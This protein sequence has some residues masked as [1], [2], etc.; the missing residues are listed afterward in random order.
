M[1][2][3]IDGNVRP[4]VL[5]RKRIVRLRDAINL[6]KYYEYAR[7]RRILNATKRN[8]FSGM[9]SK[10]KQRKI[11]YKY[12]ILPARVDLY[13]HCS[14]KPSYRDS[15][16]RGPLWKWKLYC[17]VIVRRSGLK[18]V[19]KYSDGNEGKGL[20]FQR[21]Q[22]PVCSEQLGW[23]CRGNRAFFDFVMDRSLEQRYAV[24]FCVRFLQ[25]KHSGCF[26]RPSRT[27]AFQGHSP[28]GGTR[29]SRRARRSPTNPDLDA[30]QRPES[31]KTWIVC[32]F[33][34]SIEP[35][36]KSLTP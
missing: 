4:T 19:G 5:Q 33:R 6:S 9:P 13:V 34:P 7:Y 15:Y 12:R 24:K 32:A 18:S 3:H 30:Q 36:S 26:E 35:F 11:E 2:I 23:K 29:R 16:I 14:L 22:S 8:R 25:P 28:E 31:M 20:P 1:Y 27:T 10:N 17:D 21:N